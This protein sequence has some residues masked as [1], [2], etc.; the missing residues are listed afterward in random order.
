[1]NQI[2]M[3]WDKLLPYLKKFGLFLKKSTPFLLKSF[4]VLILALFLFFLGGAYLEWSENKDRV[5]QNLDKFES[6]ISHSYDS[7]MTQPIKIFDKNEQQ[8]GEFNRKNYKPIRLDN[9]EK[10]HNL[11]WA[12]L[13]SEDR[14]FWNHKGINFNALIRAIYVNLTN[15]RFVQG[16]STITQQLAKLSLNLGKRNIFN[17]ATEAFCTLYIENQYSKDKIL[18]MYMNQIFMGEGNV[19]LEEASRYYY[20]K[21]ATDLTPAEAA[22]L[23]GVIPAPSVYNPVRNLT[24][25]LERQERILNAMG[26]FPD[27]NLSKSTEEK[28]SEEIPEHIRKFH[29][30]YDVKPVK[31]AEPKKF[32]SGIGKSGYDR[33]FIKNLA[34]DFNDT[35]RSIVLSM[36]SSEE[37]E[38]RSIRVYTTLDF[39]KQEIAEKLLKEGIDKVREELGKRREAYSKKENKEEAGREKE[40]ID[41]MNGSIVS[42]NPYNGNI[43]AMVGSYR[44]SNSYQLN[45]AEDARRQP[46]SSIKGLIYT[47]AL[48]QRIIT[49][50]SIVV[51]EKLDFG[52][53]SPKNWYK[54]YKGSMTARQALAQSVNT[55]S[56][57]LLHQIGTERF[58]TKLS[59]I[60]NLPY[61][62]LES[63]MGN[64]LSLALGSGELSPME[65]ATI[66]ATIAN[67][68]MRITPKRILK[69]VDGNG[70]ILYVPED[71]GPQIQVLDPVA[72]AMAIQLMEAVLSEEGTMIVKVKDSDRP[73]MAG[74]T[75]TVQIP[76]IIKKKWGGRSGVRDS[77]FAGIAPGLVSTVW[78]GNDQGAPFPGSGSGNSGQIWLRYTLALKQ[79]VGFEDAL[80]RPIDENCTRVDICGETGEALA[81][82]EECKYPLYSQYYY[83]G[84][85]PQPLPKE[86]NKIEIPAYDFENKEEEG[87]QH[88]D[89]SDTTINPPSEPEDLPPDPEVIT[90]EESSPQE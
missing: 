86:E 16:G 1:M 31:G 45:R 37:L 61:S 48:E 6:E 79:R 83:R 36:F 60:L 50:S 38:R 82:A 49:P 88:F 56:V 5:K 17:K 73:P 57:K 75:G 65:L 44:I 80:I 41:G 18:V 55:V 12:L 85:E 46:G 4:A 59:D 24:I 27:L 30:S 35:I 14:D 19:G 76:G 32:T 74:K 71:E 26:R 69:I 28:F 84:D 40:I 33:D 90:P 22:L 53:Y 62:E 58:L 70:D 13:S 39:K 15:R 47:L 42:L 10:H 67:G 21:S 11:I 77:W 72:C 8:I 43:E 29:V 63:R 89:D 87:G 3:Y 25:A 64:N 51:D 7:G 20:K 78:I 9:L 54:G 52:G 81:D 34:P 23:V 68:G 66:Y 2:K